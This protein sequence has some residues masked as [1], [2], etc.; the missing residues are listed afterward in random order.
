M[1][2][3]MLIPC[4]QQLSICT[5]DMRFFKQ[6]WFYHT[7][8]RDYGL[9]YTLLC[10]QL[11]LRCFAR[12]METNFHRPSKPNVVA[13]YSLPM[14]GRRF[15]PPQTCLDSY[16]EQD[17]I[18]LFIALCFECVRSCIEAC[19]V[20]SA[21]SEAYILRICPCL[22][23]NIRPTSFLERPVICTSPNSIVTR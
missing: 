10:P 4:S 22:A 18:V 14:F 9:L 15:N 11:I 16:S 23:P 7:L 6:N 12:K 2:S 13:D 20:F 21:P 3:S 19:D 5:S 17:D 1:Y 8:L